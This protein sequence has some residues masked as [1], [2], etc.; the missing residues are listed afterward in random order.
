MAETKLEELAKK[1][2]TSK[3]GVITITLV[4]GFIILIV[5]QLVFFGVE[6]QERSRAT[7]TIQ[8]DL[9]AADNLKTD[10]VGLCLPD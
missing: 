10:C 3:A 4:I 7:S 5:C 8:D 9:V 1:R 2:K 6:L